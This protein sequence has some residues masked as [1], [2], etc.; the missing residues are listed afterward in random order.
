MSSPI[1]AVAKVVLRILPTGEFLQKRKAP[2]RTFTITK[3]T[4]AQEL[5]VNI[6]RIF[7]FFDLDAA[8]FSID[9]DSINLSDIVNDCKAFLRTKENPAFVLREEGDKIVAEAAV[10]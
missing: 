1:P 9:G 5:L 7:S 2:Q 8:V 4:D 10:S 3:N 6:A